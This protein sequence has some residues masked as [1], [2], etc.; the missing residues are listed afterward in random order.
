MYDVTDRSF[1]VHADSSVEYSI[2]NTMC[3]IPKVVLLLALTGLYSV[4]AERIFLGTEDN[5]R[6][7]FLAESDDDELL[8]DTETPQV[9]QQVSYYSYL[10]D[11]RLCAKVEYSGGRPSKPKHR[12]R[13]VI[14]AFHPAQHLLMSLEVVRPLTTPSS[15]Y[16]WANRIL[17]PFVWASPQSCRPV[18]ARSTQLQRSTVA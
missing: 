13:T 11:Y 5:I 18:V 14:L 1:P 16:R 7:R 9:Y 3:C 10:A 17:W 4:Y 8:D 6:G 15:W 2:F 12:Y